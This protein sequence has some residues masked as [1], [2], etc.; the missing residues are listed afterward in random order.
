MRRRPARLTEAI[1][2]NRR[3]LP[4]AF[5]ILGGARQRRPTLRKTAGRP[6]ASRS[7]GNRDVSSRLEHRQ[8]R[9]LADRDLASLPAAR[10]RPALAQEPEAVAAPVRPGPLLSGLQR[11]LLPDPAR[12]RRRLSAPGLA[13]RGARPARRRALGRAVPGCLYGQGLSRVVCPPAAARR[14]LAL[15]VPQ[16]APLHR[17]AGLD[18]Q[19]PL[20]LDGDRRLQV[21]HLPAAAAARRCRATSSCRSPLSRR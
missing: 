7:M 9:L 4:G 1:G 2:P 20:P 12:E 6:F 3:R 5:L 10:T 18:R 19:L 17:R 13:R 21:A 15:A 11:P 16:A 8:L 14:A